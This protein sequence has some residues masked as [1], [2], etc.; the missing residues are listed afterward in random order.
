MGQNLQDHLDV[1]LMYKEKPV[2]GGCLS[3][4]ITVPGILRVFYEFAKH[5]YL[6]K[7]EGI[8]TS[9]FAEAGGMCHTIRHDIRG[10]LIGLR[11]CSQASGTRTID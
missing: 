8:S 9:N 11:W 4:P 10:S 6:N 2:N 3:L 5:V 7:R 1:V